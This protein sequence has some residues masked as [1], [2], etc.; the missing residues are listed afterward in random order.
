[1]KK[2][3]RQGLDVLVFDQLNHQLKLSHGLSLRHQ[4]DPFNQKTIDFNFSSDTPKRSL[5]HQ[6]WFCKALA[7]D[8]NQRVRVQQV[9]DNHIINANHPTTNIEKADGVVTNQPGCN[10]ML[11]GA[12]CPLIIVYD[13]SQHAVGLAHAGWRS[14]VKGISEKL[15][16]SMQ[17]EFNCDPEHCLAGI[18][19]GICGDCFEVGQEV[20]DAVQQNSPND[21]D[22]FKPHNDRWHF[23]LIEF[24]YRQLLRSGLKESKV[25]KSGYCT[26]EE[27]ELF[28][29]YRRDGQ[30]AG[31]WALMAGL[32]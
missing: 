13:P 23:D 16:D 32:L 17:S 4:I 15:I 30:T 7:L 6:Q 2:I 3:T 24:N 8:F 9:H 20:V 25:E 19:P 29:S 11:I 28:Y 10:V 14:S 5:K 12:D 21:Q 31:R 26:F 22:L 27:N 1:M 18:G